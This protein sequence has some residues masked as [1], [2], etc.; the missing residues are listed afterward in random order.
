MNAIVLRYILIGLS[1]TTVIGLSAAGW[2]VQQMLES[3]VRQTDHAR[4]DA[5]LSAVELQQ[6]KRLEQQLTDD[7]DIIERARQ[8]AAPANQYQYQDQVIK[9]LSQYAGRL[10]LRINA[11]NFTAQA[12]QGNNNRTPFT[13]T[14][15]GPVPYE[16]FL[17]FLR[18]IEANLT[19]MQVTSLALSP[20]ANPAFIANPTLSMEVY[21]RR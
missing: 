18:D 14:L 13:I 9:D 7:K 12:L 20:D 10:G 2:W 1:A 6:L 11:F 17:R 15:D 3:K 19:R 4:I 5:Q 16:T 8:I 21:I